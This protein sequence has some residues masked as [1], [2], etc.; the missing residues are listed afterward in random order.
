MAVRTQPYPLTLTH[1]TVVKQRSVVIRKHGPRR[2]MVVSVG[3]ILSGV[4]VPFLMAIG[5]L[6]ITLLL[7]LVGLGLTATGG[8]MALIFCGEI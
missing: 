4:G 5:L 7:G 6:P 3:L 2:C 8:L 1:V